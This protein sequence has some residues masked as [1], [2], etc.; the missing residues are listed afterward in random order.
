MWKVIGASVTGNSHEAAGIGCEDASRWEVGPEVTCLAVADGAGSRPLSGRGANLAVE[1]ALLMVRVVAARDDPDDPQAWLQLI[2]NDVR[3]EIAALAKAEERDAGDFAATLG[4][5]ILTSTVACIGQIGD[6]IA[7]LGGPGGYRT[8][9]PAPRSEYVNETSFVTDDR[10]IDQ[11]RVTITP[12][13][14]VDSV[15]LSTDGLRFKVLGNLVTADPFP[16]FFEDLAAYAQSADA[17]ADEIRR[18]LADLDDQS[19]DDKTLV[20]AVR[21]GPGPE[22]T[23]EDAST[24]VS[25]GEAAT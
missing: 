5:A 2:V 6:T 8:I 25:G 23:T 15:F 19:G 4:V 3:D 20:A 22:G 9:D 14:E 24:S 11:L 17:S 21:S 18:F 10:A 12:I 13:A 7:V 16:P 1:R